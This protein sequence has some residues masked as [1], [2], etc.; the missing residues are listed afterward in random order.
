[1]SSLSVG[2]IWPGRSEVVRCMYV[3]QSPPRHH[4]ARQ[5]QYSLANLQIL[6]GAFDVMDRLLGRGLARYSQ[7][8]SL[9]RAE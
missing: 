4:D 7:G 5:T 3:I 9:L 2:E 6:P 1:M 8:K